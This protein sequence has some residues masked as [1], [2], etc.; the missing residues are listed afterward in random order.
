[1][2]ADVLD[3]LQVRFHLLLAVLVVVHALLQ[4]ALLHALAEKLR[5][6]RARGRARRVTT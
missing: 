1:V 5:V 2:H 4:I 3:G 6:S